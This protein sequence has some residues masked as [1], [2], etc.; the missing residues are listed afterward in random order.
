MPWHWG[1]E[2]QQSFEELKRLVTTT[3]VLKLPDFTLRFIVKTD[4]IRAVL[5]QGEGKDERPVALESRKLN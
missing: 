5:C 1:T 3:P 4:A 2:E